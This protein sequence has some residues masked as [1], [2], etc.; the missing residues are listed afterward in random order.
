MTA[1]IIPQ[2]VEAGETF[3]VA[4]AAAPLWTGTVYSSCTEYPGRIR[5]RAAALK[6]STRSCAIAKR[7]ARKMPWMCAGNFEK[8]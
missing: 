2:F 7:I 3:R 1:V 6:M 8:R 5:S 4:A